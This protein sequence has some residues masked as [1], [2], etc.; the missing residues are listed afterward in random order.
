M[1]TEGKESLPLDSP[2]LR[3][4]QQ[5]TYLTHTAKNKNC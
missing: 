1:Y 2:L 4:V 3:P 5:V